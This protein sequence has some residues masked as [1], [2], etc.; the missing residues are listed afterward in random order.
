MDTV[1]DDVGDESTQRM[2]IDQLIEL[3]EVGE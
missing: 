2:D 3:L 1:V